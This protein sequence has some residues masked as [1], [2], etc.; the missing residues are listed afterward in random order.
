MA[1]GQRQTVDSL[2]LLVYNRPLH[3][4][5]F[6]IYHRHVID[7]PAFDAD[8]WITGC[9]HLVGF[10][11]GGQ[12]ICEVM[13]EN[14]DLMPE[15]GLV[16]SFRCRGE[17]QHEYKPSEGMQYLMTF[18]VEQM[19]EKLFAQT[20][21][22]LLKAGEKRGVLVPFPQWQMTSEH[23]PFCYLDYHVKP[24]SLHVF[25]YH[26]FPDERTVVKTQSIFELD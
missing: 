14:D 16:A 12:T 23:I 3:P 17:R 1:L 9:S 21:G 2:N 24:K 10:H 15:R 26:A 20:H 6:D 11:A 18:Q 5:L 4:E 7:E 13:V 25:A 8:I 19:S 22:D